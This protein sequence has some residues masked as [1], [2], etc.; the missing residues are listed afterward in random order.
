MPVNL[1]QYRGVIGVFNSRYIHIKHHNIFKNAFSQSKIKQTIAKEMFSVFVS[2]QSQIYQFTS[3]QDFYF[4]VLLTF[5]HHIW[6]Y[7]II[8]NRSAD[9]EK[10]PGPKPNPCQSF[11]ICH[12]NLNSISA[13][14]FLKLSLLQAYIA[15]HNFD[16]TCLSE[17]YLDLENCLYNSKY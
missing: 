9:I 13:H 16:V 12:W 1:S 11:S 14:N 17:T 10:N 2:N 4:C 5:V 3:R 6:L 15:V 7:L 8:S